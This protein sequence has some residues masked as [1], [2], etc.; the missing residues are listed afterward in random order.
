MINNMF[1]TFWLKITS[2]LVAMV[3]LLSITPSFGQTKVKIKGEKFYINDKVTYSGQK[4]KGHKIE[5]LLMNSRM[6]QGVFDD[7]NSETIEKWEYPDTG[8]WDA[9]RNT[10]EFVKN[11][12]DWKTHGLLSFTINLQG[13]SPE[14]YSKNQ[15]WH[16]SAFTA[17]GELRP[18]YMNRLK[19]ILDEANRL[20]MVPILGLFYFGQDQRLEDEAAVIR[21]VDLAIN[22]LH[23]HNYKNVLIEINNECN[24]RYSH[25][26]LKPE[27]VHELISKAKAIERDGFRYYIST[28]YG[29]GFIPLPNVVAVAD[30]ILLHGNGVSEPEKIGEM[31]AE[32]KK[33]K[34]YHKMPIL[35][36]EDDH[37][38]FDKDI[39]NLTASVAAYASWGYFD[40][41]KKGEAFEVGYQSV[42]VDWSISSGRKKAFFNL[43]KEITGY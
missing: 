29:G 4:W 38:D 3:I 20:E 26:I 17:Q 32:T 28:S 18:A 15:P 27:R 23:D 5:G 35:F 7:L 9:D 19:K 39:N 41:R 25:E 8:K 6:V 24:V 40:F 2:T 1:F 12:A 34:G 42:P 13:G 22:W 43:L 11:M 30:F 14:G 31:V 37:F 21:A 33:V 16:N 10:A 36:N